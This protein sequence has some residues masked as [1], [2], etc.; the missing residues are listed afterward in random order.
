M[1]DKWGIRKGYLKIHIAVDVKTKK[2]LSIKVTDEH[3]HDSKALPG[4]IK[5]VIKS[6]SMTPTATIGKLFA[7]GAFDNNDVFR[8]LADNGITPC[9]KVRRNARI[10]KTNHFLRNMSVIF[11]KNNLQE[12]KDSVSFGQRWL[13]KLCSHV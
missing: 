9:I 11:Q 13:M 4:L 10:K 6:D 5:G 8:C 7:D 1:R 12:W 3:T 2:I